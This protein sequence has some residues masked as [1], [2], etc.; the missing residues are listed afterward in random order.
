MLLDILMYQ[1]KCIKFDE[2]YG[3]G[4]YVCVCTYIYLYIMTAA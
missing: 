3:M 2:P 1:E 4:M